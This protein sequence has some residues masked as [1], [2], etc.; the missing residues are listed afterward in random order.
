MA[1]ME[2]LNDM[3]K[4]TSGWGIDKKVPVALIFVVIL[5]TLGFTWGAATLSN[6]VKNN[7]KAIVKL[8]EKFEKFTDDIDNELDTKRDKEADRRERDGLYKRVDSVET[9]VLDVERGKNHQRW[10]TPAK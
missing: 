8:E 7:G 6:D 9:R 2:D 5:Q 4:S 10:D 1:S 3:E